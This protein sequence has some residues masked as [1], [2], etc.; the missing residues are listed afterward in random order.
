MNKDVLYPEGL[1]LRDILEI[2]QKRITGKSAYWG[3]PTQKN[4][5]D[6][7]VYQEIIHSIKPDFVIEIGNYMGGSAL[8]LAHLL[9]N[10]GHGKLIGVD[11]N[12]SRLA[13]QAIQHPRITFLEGD[14]KTT[15][16]QVKEAVPP[17]S[18]VLVIEDSSHEFDHTLEV[19][20]LYSSLVSLDSYLIVEDGIC[21]Y[22]LDVGPS[23][24]PYEAVLAFL[25]ENDEFEIDQDKED[26]VLT[27]NP[28]GYLKRIKEPCTK[29]PS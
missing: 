19:L 14:A 8:A 24:G 2:I 20:R 16:P 12:G 29:A 21:R 5:M 17:T 13:S 28:C 6:F 25:E 1:R 3:I 22:G 9:D 10:L 4:P 23:P 26:F 27:W 15:F 18:R 11:V 7:W